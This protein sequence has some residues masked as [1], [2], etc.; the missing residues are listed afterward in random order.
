[1]DE[2]MDGSKQSRLEVLPFRMRSLLRVLWLL[3][4]TRIC[5]DLRRLLNYLFLIRRPNQGNSYL[6]SSGWYVQYIRAC[7][8]HLANWQEQGIRTSEALRYAPRP[9]FKA[10]IFLRMCF[11]S[12]IMLS[13][14]VITAQS[15]FTEH[16]SDFKLEV[17]CWNCTLKSL[18]VG[19][20]TVTLLKP[21][22]TCVNK[23]KRSFPL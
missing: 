3:V 18:A 9:F 14:S 10:R 2:Q 1:M 4:T 20:F 19:I 21:M 5:S 16:F 12:L 15:W 17:Y 23:K 7:P 8:T 11:M 13:G 22:H 6:E